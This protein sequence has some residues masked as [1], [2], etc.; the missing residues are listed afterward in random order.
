[1]L[2]PHYKIIFIELLSEETYLVTPLGNDGRM[3]I[4]EKGHD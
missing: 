1:M 3:T 4:V 2:I